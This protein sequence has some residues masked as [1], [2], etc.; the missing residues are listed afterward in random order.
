[1]KQTFEVKILDQK[2]VLKTEN[3]ED[4]VKRVA[5]YVN[6]VMHAIKQRSATI[7]TQNVA[8]LGALNIAEDLFAKNDTTKDM[9]TDWKERLEEIVEP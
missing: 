2:F 8:I 9:I 4:H 1:M 6:K 7:S 3:S 5:D